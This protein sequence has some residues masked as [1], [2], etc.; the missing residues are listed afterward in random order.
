M[1]VGVSKRA[2]EK[3]VHPTLLVAT[4][5][6]GALAGRQLF[7]DGMTN[8]VQTL[9]NP[10]W[11]PSDQETPRRLFSLLWTTAPIRLVG[12]FA[13]D[14]IKSAKIIYGVA[15]YLQIA[16]PLISV[17]RSQLTLI[18]RSLLIILFVAATI[19][20]ANFA[21]T[22]LLFAL[23]LTTMFVVYALDG[24]PDPQFTKRL[25]IG[26]L[27]IA[28]YEV[29]AVSNV[30]LAIGTYV[31]TAPHTRRQRLLI[32][33]LCAALP[34]QAL[35]FFSEPSLPGQNVFNSFVFEIAGIA[36][37]V[38]AA[39]ILIAKSIS[40]WQAAQAAMIFICFAVPILILLAPD[41]FLYLRTREFQYSYPSRVFSAGITVL[42]A[43]LPLLLNRSI[44]DWP[45]RSLAWIGA[46]SLAQ[47]AAASLVA[48]YSVSIAASW[49]A[50]SYWERLWTE[51]SQYS[52]LISI[53]DC[54]FCTNPE[55]FGYANLGQPSTWPAYSMAYSLQYGQHP[56]VVA[57]VKEQAAGEIKTGQIAN[58]LNREPG[59]LHSID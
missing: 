49:D 47:L 27:L 46:R 15:A 14:S 2:W 24:R 52:G 18:I 16:I 42:I 6:L 33:I 48:F 37:L 41:H 59:A 44:L 13:P 38:L 40:R 20:L 32:A 4:V 55:E 34:F 29:V 56:R 1:F 9:Q 17:L 30:L 43:M 21:A 3:A 35:C 54:K 28:S 7:M 5:L 39:G 8:V 11:F 51:S 58:F 26:F 10:F 12:V 36:I 19:F 57:V 45:S 25:I 23:G 53:E 31:S 50:Y 22:E